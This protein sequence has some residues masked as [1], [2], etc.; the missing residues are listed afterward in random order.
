M[1]GRGRLEATLF[2]QNRVKAHRLRGRRPLSLH[3]APVHGLNLGAELRNPRLVR[4]EVPR[5]PKFRHRV[6][7]LSLHGRGRRIQSVDVGIHL[8]DVLGARPLLRVDHSVLG[9]RALEHSDGLLDDRDP[10]VAHGGV[11]LPGLPGC[12][13]L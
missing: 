9:Q 12:R 8:P 6:A 13:T 1:Q 3:T 2:P 10:G 7:L 11:T 4:R 5:R